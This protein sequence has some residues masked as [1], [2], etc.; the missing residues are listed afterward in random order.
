MDFR[1]YE[2]ILDFNAKMVS[3]INRIRGANRSLD[4]DSVSY[5]V[6][7]KANETLFKMAADCTKVVT[8]KDR[9]ED[10]V[11]IFCFDS[12]TNSSNDHMDYIE[13]A[14]H[15]AVDHWLGVGARV[16]RYHG[17]GE[18]IGKCG[19]IP[20]H[21]CELKWNKFLMMAAHFTEDVKC[22]A[23]DYSTLP[24][25]GIIRIACAFQQRYLRPTDLAR[26]QLFD[27]G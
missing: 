6:T 22:E 17:E 7:L 9:Y 25:N 16:F 23:L 18:V 2:T 4:A 20:V 11:A 10:G 3:E 24:S 5:K 15:T 26:D 13:Q 19:E 8:N 27:K 21:L 12:R 1:T 14:M